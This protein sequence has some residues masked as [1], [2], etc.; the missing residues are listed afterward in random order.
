MRLR[1]SLG[2]PTATRKLRLS[3]GKPHR[4]RQKFLGDAV[5]DSSP[6]PSFATASD[7]R[8]AAT[9]VFLLLRG[10]VD[11]L[12]V[13]PVNQ[14]SSEGSLEAIP[15][16]RARRLRRVAVP[17]VCP[18]SGT[19][20]D[21]ASSPRRHLEITEAY[22]SHPMGRSLRPDRKHLGW[23][24]SHVGKGLP[25]EVQGVRVH[26]RTPRRQGIPQRNP[27]GTRTGRCLQRSR[28]KYG[29]L[30]GP[31]RVEPLSDRA[32]WLFVPVADLVV[33]TAAATGYLPQLRGVHGA[34]QFRAAP[35]SPTAFSATRPVPGVTGTLN[36]YEMPIFH[37]HAIGRERCHG[38]GERT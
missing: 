36:R 38:P 35:F 1:V 16:P 23:P 9:V 34:A 27:T 15:L 7:C 32:R 13:A 17:D 20:G 18:G 5:S 21:A 12:A 4:P 2:E 26:D 33:H 24:A 29:L 37:G 6:W 19:V 8:A 22:R 11:H 28:L 25:V 3:V 14:G 10:C 31:V 30:S